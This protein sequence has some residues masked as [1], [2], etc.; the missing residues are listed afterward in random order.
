MQDASLGLSFCEVSE[1]WH[2]LDHGKSSAAMHGGRWWAHPILDQ[3]RETDWMW[4]GR[5]PGPKPGNRRF[6]KSP[7][8]DLHPFVNPNQI[9]I[10][11]FFSSHPFPLHPLSHFAWHQRMVWGF[12]FHWLY[13]SLTLSH[14]ASDSVCCHTK[15]SYPFPPP[16]QPRK[17]ACI[18]WEF[19]MQQ[20][21]DMHRHK[22]LTPLSVNYPTLLRMWQVIR[23][24]AFFQYSVIC[25]FENPE[26][27]YIHINY[28]YIYSKIWSQSQR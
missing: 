21:K 12:P 19:L 27:K 3:V 1:A 28:I 4:A 17:R 9:E 6:D 5:Q 7:F 10:S 16:R 14:H 15:I 2:L 24:G 26:K 25:K 20:S 11:P 23:S 8:A 13:A 22:C 18:G